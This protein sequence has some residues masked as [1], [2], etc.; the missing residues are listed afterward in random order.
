MDSRNPTDAIKAQLSQ[1]RLKMAIKASENPIKRSH[2]LNLDIESNV[3]P[4]VE[5]GIKSHNSQYFYWNWY[6]GDGEKSCICLHLVYSDKYVMLLSGL[7]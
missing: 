1:V 2:P 7:G 4:S 3:F 5:H 6:T